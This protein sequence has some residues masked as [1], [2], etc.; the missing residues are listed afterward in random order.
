MCVCTRMYGVQC[1]A[2][3]VR[4]QCMRTQ[5]VQGESGEINRYIHP[6]KRDGKGYIE[7]EGDIVCENVAR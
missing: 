2:Y 4:V 1:M 6:V 3:T 5:C 7:K